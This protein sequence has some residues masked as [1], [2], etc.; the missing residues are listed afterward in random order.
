MKSEYYLATVI[1]AYRRCMDAGFS[2]VTERELITSSP[3]LVLAAFTVNDLPKSAFGDKTSSA[4]P[5]LNLPRISTTA[6]CAAENKFEYSGEENEF[7]L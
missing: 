5:T 6:F 2:D 7:T 3:A 1:N 4:S